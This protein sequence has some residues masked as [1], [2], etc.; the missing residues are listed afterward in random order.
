V[1]ALAVLQQ[2]AQVMLERADQVVIMLLAHR[3]V[4]TVAVE[5]VLAVVVLKVQFVLS[6]DQVGNIQL[7][8][9]NV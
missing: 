3:V 6:G 5:V 4:Y 7:E 2:E 8:Q 9:H 1:L